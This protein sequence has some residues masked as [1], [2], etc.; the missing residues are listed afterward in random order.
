MGRHRYCPEIARGKRKSARPV[1]PVLTPGKAA[2]D[3]GPAE[4][5]QEADEADDGE[6]GGGEEQELEEPG[7]AFRGG[8]LER[9]R[10]S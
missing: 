6:A 10:I 7:R 4:E 9:N 5:P 3:A 1:R 2:H 8:L